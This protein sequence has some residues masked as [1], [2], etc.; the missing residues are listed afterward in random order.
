MLYV[1]VGTDP[2]QR[3][4]ARHKVWN[5]AYTD[6]D[7]ASVSA[8]EFVSLIATDSLFG[9][10]KA[11]RVQNVIT[12]E[13][14]EGLSG[15][16]VLGIAQDLVESPHTFILE[17]DKLLAGPK[18]A[19]EKAGATIVELKAAAKKEPFNVF[20]LG[21]ALGKR[22]RKALWLLLT[23]AFMGGVAPENIAGILAW[24]ARSMIPAVR[25]EQEKKAW[26]RISRELVVMYHE[27][28]RGGGDLALLLERFALTL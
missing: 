20:A 3:A 10:V 13:T 15:E 2:K 8:E 5:G 7:P 25:T 12:L 24:K 11:Y 9:E 19:L 4:A 21:G 23:Q 28:H 1:I 26:A 16:T 18:R 22:D 17:E 27:S 6:I 14:E